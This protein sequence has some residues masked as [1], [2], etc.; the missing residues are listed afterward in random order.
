MPKD[1]KCLYCD[2]YF[3]SRQA[4]AQH[5]NRTHYD[6]NDTSLDDKDFN[7]IN[8]FEEM[9]TGW[10]E[11]LPSITN[12]NEEYEDQNMPPAS[13]EY[14]DVLE[15]TDVVSNFSKN[16][17]INQ[18]SQSNFDQSDRFEESNME[19]Y[20]SFEQVSP[21]RFEESNIEDYDNFE[22]VSPEREEN[23]MEFPNEAY[24]D[25]MELFIK[26]NLNNK[27]GN[28]IIKFFDK[29]SNLSTSPLPKNI[30]AGRKLMD[31]MNVQKLPYSKHCILDY[32]NK[33]YFVYYR[34]IKSCIESLLSNPDIIKNFIYKYQFL[35][36][37]GETLYSEQYSG[38]WW[39]NAEA[40][41]RPEAHI[42]SII[43]Y[44]DATTTDSLG[45]SSL[46]PIY[47]SLGNIRTWRRNKEDAKQLLGYLPILSANNEGQT[48][49]FKR[50]ARETFHNSLKFLL[51]PLFDEDGIDFKINNKNI[52]FFP[53]IS[54][55]LLITEVNVPNE[56]PFHLVL[57]QW[58]DYRFDQN[59]DL[60]DCPL[61]K[62]VEWYNFIEI[63]A[64]EDIVHMVPR[65]D[66][67]NEYFVNKYLF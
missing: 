22:Q 39:K 17:D 18:T 65:F 9:Q 14:E 28:A 40:S 16:Y 50:L 15:N 8:R 37:D 66:E 54:T 32:K 21:D 12:E 49:R 46:H 19:D 61:L 58:Y 41:I 62:L 7:R 52:W 11:S 51:D 27:T 43:L 3:S 13:H 38:N 42:L 26:H 2:R 34:P 5:V 1:F 31:I 35:Q 10:E 53:R 4:Y 36:S 45:K 29:H 25:L 23:V 55:T 56:S 24:A 60:Y 48:S 64:I 47:I 67:T 20:Y 33:E 59:S 6:I 44:S 30:E 57:V 63:E